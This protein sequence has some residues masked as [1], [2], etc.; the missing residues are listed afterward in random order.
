MKKSY[1]TRKDSIILTAI[2]IID[3]LGL[4]GLTTRELARRQEV[5]EPALYR[6]FTNRHEIIMGIL[7]YYSRFD[8]SIILT[9]TNRK[10]ESKEG[11]IFFV[12]SYAEYFENYPAITAI[13]DSY[14]ILSYDPDTALKIKEIFDNRSNFI[15]QLV[16]AGQRK[17]EICTDFI[18]EDL[19]D[20]ILGL[21]RALILKWRMNHFNFSL[22]A[23]T[24]SALETLLLVCSENRKE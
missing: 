7:D 21:F 10:L 22:K 17:G 3:E 13:V 9:I 4:S 14:E 23:R 8:T 6:H 16:E 11:I 5:S 24:L 19:A 12:K 18:T 1:L 20:I 15:I 2:E